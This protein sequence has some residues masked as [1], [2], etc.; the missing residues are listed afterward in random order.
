[1]LTCK[2]A[3]AKERL[4]DRSDGAGGEDPA[5]VAC[6]NHPLEARGRAH[7]VERYVHRVGLEHAVHCNDCHRRLW[8]EEA[9]AVSATDAGCPQE[10]GQA[11]ARP[12]EL[13]VGHALTLE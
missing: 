7:R 1:M 9:D 3:V 12:L 6:G 5:V 8:H 10:M 4:E 13:A 2:I 11:I